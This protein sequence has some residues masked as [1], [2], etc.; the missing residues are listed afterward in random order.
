ML[1][2]EKEAAAIGR[3]NRDAALRFDWNLLVAQFDRIY[4]SL[5]RQ[6]HE[7]MM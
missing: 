1:D 6:R 7:V 4:E 3:R 5:R 2:N